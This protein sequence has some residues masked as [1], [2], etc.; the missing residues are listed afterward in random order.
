MSFNMVFDGQ[1]LELQCRQ[2]FCKR[3]SD[4]NCKVIAKSSEVFN[5]WLKHLQTRPVDD[6][7]HCK[8]KKEGKA[9]VVYRSYLK[10]AARRRRRVEIGEYW[11]CTSKFYFRFGAKKCLFL[12]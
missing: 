1:Q 7:G 11:H 5:F 2:A 12:R 9:P 6:D 3:V 8:A 4:C 10:S